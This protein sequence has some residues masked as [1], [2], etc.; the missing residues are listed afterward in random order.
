MVQARVDPILAQAPQSGHVV[1]VEAQVAHGRSFFKEDGD[2]DV[3][4]LGAPQLPQLLVLA[5]HQADEVS[6]R[7]QVLAGGLQRTGE[8]KE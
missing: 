6:H 4:I 3:E 1:H 8:K 5:A 7:V 2:F